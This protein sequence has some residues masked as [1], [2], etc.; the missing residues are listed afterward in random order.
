MSLP[1]TQWSLFDAFETDK[2]SGTAWNQFQR[3]YSTP[4]RQWFLGR[5]CQSAD[6]DDLTQLVMVKLFQNLKSF[7]RDRGAFRPWLRTLLQHA[8][9]DHFRDRQRRPA[10][11]ATGSDT[12]HELLAALAA[13]E[14][15]DSLCAEVETCQDRHMTQAME[16][17]RLKTSEQTWKAFEGLFIQNQPAS[18]VAQAVGLSIGAVHQARYRVLGMI[19]K[20]YQQLLA[21]A[22]E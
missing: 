18:A 2:S 15:L 20:E 9:M 16:T 1:S 14:P 5:Q 21:D 13:D 22:G 19:G 10:N 6:A 17:V 4:I 11:F 8:L 7:D 3:V 12:A